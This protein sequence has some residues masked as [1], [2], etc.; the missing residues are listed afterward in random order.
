MSTYARLCRKIKNGEGVF[1][2]EKL[3]TLEGIINADNE[4]CYTKGDDIIKLPAHDDYDF[5]F[6][7]EEYC[8]SDLTPEEDIIKENP[9]LKTRV[10]LKNKYRKDT[11]KE[12]SLI[13]YDKASKCIETIYLTKKRLKEVFEISEDIAMLHGLEYNDDDYC[14]TFPKGYVLT[15]IKQIRKLINYLKN[16]EIEDVYNILAGLSENYKYEHEADDVIATE[17]KKQKDEGKTEIT[18]DAE[19][20]NGKDKTKNKTEEKDNSKTYDQLIEELKRLIGM[21]KIKEEVEDLSRGL[22]YN[23]RI[24]NEKLDIVPEKQN[25]NMVFLG[26]PGTGKTTI[27]FILS[28][29]LNKLGYANGKFKKITA[30][31]LIG[32]FVGE[33]ENKTAKLLKEMKGGVIFMDEAYSLTT[34]VAELGDS[35]GLQALNVLIEE[36]GRNDTIFIFA[37]YHKEMEKFI[38]SNSGF[39]SRIQGGYFNFRDYTLDELMQMFINK[40]NKSKYILADGVLDEVRKI[41]DETMRQKDFGNGRFVDHLYGQIIKKHASNTVFSKNL[42]DL[43]TITLDDLNKVDREILSYQKILT[44]KIGF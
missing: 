29:I 21:E 11:N 42:D 10:Q 34:G 36:M 22:L 2:L 5:V 44:P 37:G 43:K 35:F 14:A 20:L 8:Y 18:V 38:E 30:Q 26:N 41:I 27:A 25:L 19:E 6:S 39:K 17:I 31:D 3:E 23:E 16:N 32:N 13:Y 1:T 12:I 24:E 33:S 15:T 40:V 7:D 28:E 4:F 9:G